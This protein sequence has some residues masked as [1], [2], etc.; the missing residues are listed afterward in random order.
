MPVMRL[1]RRNHSKQDRCVRALAGARR[2]R[3]RPAVANCGGLLSPISS[4]RK[5]AA[6][7]SAKANDVMILLYRVS[8]A[9]HN[10]ATKY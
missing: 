2:A 3:R 7:R 1:C 5:A 8:N 9:T 10:T 6:D 4:N